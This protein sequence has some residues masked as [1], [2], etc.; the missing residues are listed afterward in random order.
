MIL[1]PNGYVNVVLLESPYEVMQSFKVTRMALKIFTIYGDGGQLC[2]V[3]RTTSINTFI[4]RCDIYL[5]S[6]RN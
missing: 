4:I 1:L 2:H 3:I 6:T 5:A